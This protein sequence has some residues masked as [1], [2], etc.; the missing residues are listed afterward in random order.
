MEEM[1]QRTP[2]P[3]SILPI[4]GNNRF[5]SNFNT[6]FSNI[7]SSI[8]RWQFVLIMWGQRRWFWEKWGQDSKLLSVWN[9]FP[10]DSILWLQLV[11]LFSLYIQWY[12][13]SAMISFLIPLSSNSQ[14]YAIIR[15]QTFAIFPLYWLKFSNNCDW[16]LLKFHPSIRLQKWSTSF[17]ESM[18]MIS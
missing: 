1:M 5:R 6:N 15:P 18:R 14:L 2:G 13:W 4:F 10:I 11:M 7:S 9:N 12:F 17:S 3:K 16:W 8:Q